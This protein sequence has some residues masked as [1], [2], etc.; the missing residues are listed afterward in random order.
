MKTKNE[1]ASNRRVRRGVRF[2][3]FSKV[4]NSLST[5]GSET[6]GS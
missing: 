3:I 6:P 5:S 4:A 1:G 2:K